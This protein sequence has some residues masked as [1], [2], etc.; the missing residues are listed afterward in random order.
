MKQRLGTATDLSGDG[1]SSG[2]P[3][4]S[5][6]FRLLQEKAAHV[7]DRQEVCRNKPFNVFSVLRSTHYQV[8]LHSRYQA[9]VLDHRQ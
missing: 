4:T 7:Y 2:E 3:V 9:A 6:T 8:N 5:A 1:A